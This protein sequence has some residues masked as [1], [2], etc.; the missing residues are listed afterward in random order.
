MRSFIY[1]LLL[2]VL[3]ICVSLNNVHAHVGPGKNNKAAKAKK[4]RASL[5]TDCAQATAQVDQ[6]INNVRARLL[7]GGD[8]WWDGDSNGRYVVPKVDPSSGQEERSSIFAGAVWIGGVDDAGVL[9]IAAQTYGSSQ[10]QTDFWPGPLTD[11]GF[12]DANTCVDWDRFFKVLGTEIDQHLANYELFKS[13]G[14]DYDPDLIPDGVKYWP[15]RGNVYF[16]EKYG[17]DLPDN[18]QGL[19]AFF[20]VEA[21]DV[22]EPEKGEFPIIEIA[23]CDDYVY[24]DEMY[25]W[26]YNDAGG[27]HTESEG[28]E[29]RMEI[30]VQAFA[31]ATNDEINNMTFQRYKLINRA[32]ASI[33]S[34]FFAMWVD[35]DLGCYT[36]DYI[37][38]DSS[39][40]FAYIYNED[41]QDGQSGCDCP[42]NVP[43]YCTEIPA[44]GIDYFRGPRDE[45]FEELGMSSFMYYN[46]P[47][48]SGLPG[49]TDPQT[50]VEFYRYLTGHWRDGTPLTKGGSGYDVAST[51]YTRYAFTGEPDDVNAWSM[52]SEGL[53][54]GDR[55]TL[56]ATG[57]FRLDPG[58]VNELIIGAVWVPELEYPC[59][60]ISSLLAADD[61]AQ[62]LFDNCFELLDGPDAP[63]VDWVELDREL[64]A[65]LTNDI[66]T[67]ANNTN[68]EYQEVDIFAPEDVPDEDKTYVFE[69]YRIFQLRGPGVGSGDL[70]NPDLARIVETV[71]IKNGVRQIFNWKGIPNPNTDPFA[72]DLIWQPTV[73]TENAQD[74]GI[75]H[76]FRIKEDQFAP[77]D[78]RLINHR[79]Y[80]YM[81]IAYAHN[82]YERF[83]QI[84]DN[85]TGQRTPYL[86]GRRNIQLYTVMPR[87][88]TDVKLNAAYG[89]LA[90]ITRL[91]GEGAGGNYL[92]IEKETRE[93]MLDPQFDERI[94]YR[95]GLGPIEVKV[96][97]PLSIRD[98]N[99]RLDFFD[100]NTD[101]D[102]LDAEV[103]WTLTNLDDNTVIAADRT[104]DRLNEQIIPEYGFSISI[105]QGQLPGL[106]TPD[107]GAIGAGLSFENPDLNWLTFISDG[108]GAAFRGV[109]NFVRTGLSEKDQ[110][111]DPRQ[112]L[113]NLADGNIVPFALTCYE[114]SEDEPI[115]S[116]AWMNNNGKNLQKRLEITQLNNVD[117]VFTPD[118]TK[119]SRC[120]VVETASDLL[121]NSTSSLE[122]EGDTEQFDLRAAP[123]VSKEDL[124][125]DGLPDPDNEVDEQG[126]PLIGMGWFPGYAVDVETGERLNIFFGENTLYSEES[127]EYFGPGV[128]DQPAISGKRL[129]NDMMW[130]PSNQVFLA[131]NRRVLPQF[132][133][134]GQHFIYV[135]NETYDGCEEMRKLLADGKTIKKINALKNITWTGIPALA[136]DQQLLSYADGLIPTEAVYEV[137]VDRP[138]EVKAGTNVNKGYPS[139]EFTF[140]GVAPE[141]MTTKME[142][143]EQ[144]DAISVVPNPYYGYSTYETSQFT[145][146]VKITNL[147]AKCT[148]TIF[149]LDGK[150]IREYRR[151]LEGADLSDRNKKGFLVGQ[152]EPDIEWDLNNHKGVPVASGVYLIYVDAPGLGER[153]LK[154][155]GIGRQFDPSNL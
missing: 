3:L 53:Q 88:I 127:E 44:L 93:S 106:G 131:S 50:A 78:R 129:G 114:D 150:F 36:D 84:G 24:P 83:L 2:P 147:P 75:R 37:G 136:S 56:Q 8:T 21:N 110:E 118:K 79:K 11:E 152:I 41:V 46:N 155:F 15:G 54:F 125:G 63:D 55:R 123:S 40:S 124:D 141:A 7:T 52:C 28:Q 112:S 19:G 67:V 99:F 149:T 143:N 10:G 86:S 94:P 82:E 115:I 128:Y 35:P 154:W 100:E 61:L 122:T 49:T 76:S 68:E 6:A 45:F 101:N 57:P 5:R 89:D 30:Q 145:K 62:S 18:V 80:Y 34:T 116:P 29:I 17:F 98:G 16:A 25:Y 135:T 138:F 119:W 51:D 39:R 126:N 26:I 132:V 148:V 42:Q 70:D 105:E 4:K 96:I 91:D 134:G 97:S 92:S 77:T 104:I 144:L 139:Y 59:P 95:S 32:V 81:V 23:G 130:N 103:E 43:T 87:P 111:K 64:I 33:D 60:D 38:C 121:R 90:R 20:E 27:I 146:R 22:Y 69:G 117:I 102:I 153:V 66:T 133:A 13:Q 137:R 120:V 48:I 109:F 85:I 72:P 58:A 73:K 14:I 108:E 71:D 140:E 65:I 113:T 151:N 9:K 142:V 12:V 47:V 1:T 74:E 31:Y 107:N